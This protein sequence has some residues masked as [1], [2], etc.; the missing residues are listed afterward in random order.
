MGKSLSDGSKRITSL[1]RFFGINSKDKFSLSLV[2]LIG[3]FI[4]SV[5]NDENNA[6]V[7]LYTVQ[8]N[9]GGAIDLW[10]SGERN[11]VK[12]RSYGDSF[13]NAGNV[14]IGTTS[15]SYKLHVNGTAYATGAAGSLSDRRHKEKIKTLSDGLTI[16]TKL[17]PVSYN[18][19]KEQIVDDGM[20]GQQ[21]GFIAQEVEKVLPFTVLTEKNK[22]KTKSLKYNEFI[23]VLVKAVQELKTEKDLEIKELKEQN[24]LLKQVIC[25][26]F[27]NKEVCLKK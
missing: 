23:P 1:V 27:P 11:K 12:I 21:L 14:G 17:R 13:F 9:Y 10:D 18:W 4:L 25:E 7:A 3:E 5:K 6:R 20:K 22:E 16:L 26:E 19:K 8:G 15:P 24:N 2:E